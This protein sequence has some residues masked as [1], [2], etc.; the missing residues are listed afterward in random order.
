MPEI[1][2]GALGETS[3]RGISPVASFPDSAQERAEGCRG[4]SKA[5]ALLQ[6]AAQAAT[7]NRIRSKFLAALPD[8][9][10]PQLR[11]QFPP[12]QTAAGGYHADQ[13][14]YSYRELR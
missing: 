7:S 14:E 4:I 5:A 3:P 9:A 12:P 10:V 8:Q 1:A 13:A 6:S 2:G 11:A